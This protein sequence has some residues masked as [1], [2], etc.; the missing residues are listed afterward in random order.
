MRMPRRGM[1]V[2]MAMEGSC[3][4]IELNPAPLHAVNALSGPGQEIIFVGDN[5]GA[6]VKMIQ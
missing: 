4:S 3:I 1:P 6:D 2:Q 5:D